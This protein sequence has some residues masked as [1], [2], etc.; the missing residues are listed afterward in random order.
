MTGVA[1]VV[2]AAEYTAPVPGNHLIGEPR[3]VITRFEDD[4]VGLADRFDVGFLALSAANPDLNPSLPGEGTVIELPVSHLLPDTPHHGVVVNLAELRLYYY[5]HGSAESV[6]GSPGKVFTF[7]IGIGKA[8]WDTPVSKTR[9]TRIDRN[10]VWVPPQSIV[11]EYRKVGGHLPR[12]VPAGPDNPL[13]QIALRLDLPGYLLH[14]T[15]NEAGVG[16]RVSHG[17]MRLRNRD[18][19]ILASMVVENTPVTI[20]DQPVKI[21]WHDGQ[22]YVEAHRPLDD[23]HHEAESDSGTI[24]YAV[25]TA[26]AKALAVDKLSADTELLISQFL[27]RQDLYSGVP[28][29]L[30]IGIEQ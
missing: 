5:H 3:Q 23:L 10:P 20:V 14:G 21:G 27:K 29:K 16:M 15:N 1:G 17:C 2:K 26:V 19:S 22:L 8:G 4:F 25:K 6:N 9:I 12:I 30:G 11:E 28:R 18:I 24:G 7:P 13:G